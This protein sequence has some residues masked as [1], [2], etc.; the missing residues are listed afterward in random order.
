MDIKTNVSPTQPHVMTKDITLEFNSDCNAWHYG[1]TSHRYSRD[2]THVIDVMTLVEPKHDSDRYFLA[3]SFLSTSFTVVSTK[4]S[5]VERR[6]DASSEAESEE[7][8]GE[9]GESGASEHPLPLCSA[10]I[11]HAETSSVCPLSE[12]I[13]AAMSTGILSREGKVGEANGSCIAGTESEPYGGKEDGG[14]SK[15]D[16]TL[17]SLEDFCLEAVGLLT[18]SDPLVRKWMPSDDY[19]STDSELMGS[20]KRARVELCESVYDVGRADVTST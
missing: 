1:W 8:G 7:E 10:D 13:Q 12:S 18:E 3:G 2:K 15:S 5:R 16:D 20:G 9:E 6:T 17:G 14:T 11:V 19:L 4:R